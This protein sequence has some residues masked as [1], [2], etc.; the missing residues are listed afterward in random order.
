MDM[1]TQRDSK[2]N[3]YISDKIQ[4]NE[5]KTTIK[6]KNERKIMGKYYEKT[7]KKIFIFNDFP[8]DTFRKSNEN[9]LSDTIIKWLEYMELRIMAE[10]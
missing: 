5:P 10:R 7:S 8:E 4:L 2:I 1:Q 6:S 9:I 3:D